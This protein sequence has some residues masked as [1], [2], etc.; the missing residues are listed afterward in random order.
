MAK[1]SLQELTD[2]LFFFYLDTLFSAFF[3]S[4]VDLSLNKQH[5]TFITFEYA[6]TLPNYFSLLEPIH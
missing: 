3:S 6:P 1:K 4:F 5:W 2:L